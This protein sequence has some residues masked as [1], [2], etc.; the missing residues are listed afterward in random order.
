[1]SDFKF[2]A[3]SLKTIPYLNLKMSEW[4]KNELL[5]VKFFI[6]SIKKV[7]IS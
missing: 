7:H 4:I 3:V 6:Q 2:C 5:Y 1:M